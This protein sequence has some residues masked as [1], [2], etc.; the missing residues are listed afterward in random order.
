MRIVFLTQEYPPFMQGGT[1]SH[2][3]ELASELVRLG[4]KV[5]VFSHST[6]RGAIQSGGVTVDFISTTAS[7]SASSAWTSQT[8][9]DLNDIAA[10]QVIKAFQGQMPPDVI[11]SH[12]FFAHP[13]A[14]QVSR[15]FGIPLITTIHVLLSSLRN[16]ASMAIDRWLLDAEAAACLESNHLIA[17]S[18]SIEQE[19]QGEYNINSESITTIYN[20]MDVSRFVT[21]QTVGSHH[22]PNIWGAANGRRTVVFGGRI[23]PQ[24]GLPGLLQSAACVRKT[25]PNLRYVIAGEDSTPYGCYI[26][27]LAFEVEQLDNIEFVG[28]L[29][30]NE[31]PE[32][33]RL[34]DLAVVPSV[35]EPF[36][37]A[38]LEAMALGVPVIASATGGLSEI[39][40]HGKSGLLVPLTRTAEGLSPDVDALTN[41]Q[42]DLLTQDD[43][44]RRLG[45]AG[46]RRVIE[47]FSSERMAHE[48]D[49]LYK[50]VLARPVEVESLPHVRDN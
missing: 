35:Y 28:F 11:H 8:V 18:R 24:K 30:R 47:A 40:E 23:D 33:Y 25:F 21:P 48:T 6:E 2:A 45:E 13:A 12:S 5:H 20:G 10:S 1:A 16:S 46:R 32:L 4:H 36:G 39:I 26:K 31:L 15:A 49:L 41:A 22:P 29:P 14:K 43:M 42:L 50:K 27:R 19:V 37:Y 17:V 44:R 3:Y 34:A 7:P 38:A 9:Q